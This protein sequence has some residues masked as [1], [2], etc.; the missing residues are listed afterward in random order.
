MFN[1]DN[2]SL[3]NTEA[4]AV[5]VKRDFGNASL[6]AVERDFV[7]FV[8]SG[9]GAYED[10]PSWRQAWRDFVE[11]CNEE[12]VEEEVTVVGFVAIGF[13]VQVLTAQNQ[14]SLF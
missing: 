8:T 5:M 10:Y 11:S 3:L 4:L 13:P 1:A 9:A 7:E 14:I 6:E 12:E 2:I